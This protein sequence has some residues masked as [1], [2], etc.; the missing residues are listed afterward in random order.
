MNTHVSPKRGKGLLRADRAFRS[1]GG[2]A[3][4]MKHAPSGL[5]PRMLDR[6][7][8]GLD[9]GTID[10]HLPHRSVRLPGGRGK[11][12]AAIVPLHLWAAPARLAHSGPVGRCCALAQG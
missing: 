12:P 1:R 6:T 5:F 2:F 4:L 3:W 7:D 9:S 8:A 10:G 11:G